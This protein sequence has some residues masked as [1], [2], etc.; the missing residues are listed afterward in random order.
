MAAVEAAQRVRDGLDVDEAP[1]AGLKPE[2][3]PHQGSTRPHA[4]LG[5]QSGVRSQ[6]SGAG[7]RIR[8]ALTLNP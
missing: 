1:L 5:E 6:E 4:R 7:S 2:D 3:R 8:C